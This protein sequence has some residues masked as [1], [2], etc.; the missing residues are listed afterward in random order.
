MGIRGNDVGDKAKWC[1]GQGKMVWRR[2]KDAGFVPISHARAYYIM[3]SPLLLVFLQIERNTAQVNSMAYKCTRPNNSRRHQLT[4]SSTQKNINLKVHQLK[5]SSIPKLIHSKTHPLKDSSTP[6]R[7]N[8]KAYP[9]KSSSTQRLIHSK[10]HPLE[11]SSTQKLI[12]SKARQLESSSPQKLILS[13][14]HP[15]KNSPTQKLTNSST[16]NLKNL[17]FILQC[18]SNFRAIL[19][20]ILVKK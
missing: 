20:K 8:S 4:N 13:K 12:H 5:G 1:G 2:R 17:I 6:K 18:C 14:A 15:L 16:S 9:P 19:A 11:S 3:R 10:A 7:S